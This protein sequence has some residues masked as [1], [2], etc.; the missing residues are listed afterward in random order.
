MVNPEP[1]KRHQLIFAVIL[2]PLD[3]LLLLL[4]AAT[5]Y[6]L[7]FETSLLPEAQS[8]IPFGDYLKSAALVGLVWLVIFALN[9]LYTLE[10]PRRALSET[11][12]VLTGCSFGLMGIIILIFFQ[13]E[14]FASRFVILAAWM[15]AIVFVVAGRAI[16]RIVQRILL[17][18]GITAIRS[19]VIGGNDATTDTIVGEFSKHP[20][21]GWTLAK[22]I[23]AWNDAAAAELEVQLR[24]EPVDEIF[25]ADTDLSRETMLSIIRFAEDHHLTLRYAADTLATHAVLHTTTV[26]GIPVIEVARTSLEGWGRVYK[27]VFD[28]IASIVL[29]VIL[30]PIMLIAAL[31]V[32]FTS[33]GPVVYRNERVGQNGKHLDVYK[34][35]S[36][37][38]DVSIGSQFG[39][40][41]AAL[42]YEAKLI[43][44]RGLKAGPVYKMPANDPR[45]TP[46]GR[47]IRKYS[48]DE[49]PQLFNVLA[50]N[51]SLVG[52]RPH[53][54]REVAKYERHHRRALV[55][56]PGITGL[57]QVS[58]R[59]DLDFEEE[60]RL[61]AFYVENWTPLMDLAILAKTPGA[62]LR[63]KG[64]Y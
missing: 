35:R 51:M 29:I 53:Q 61:D 9:G 44:E 5:A 49:L 34:F 2:V 58:G 26:A 22:R 55:V 21:R 37:F 48:I 36:M 39:G 56:K 25:V 8:L 3:Y 30:S 59:R 64:A 32:W 17:R 33:K 15:L 7:R 27:R 42:A 12:R 24:R 46:V 60:A 31:A 45:I 28:I 54:P 13:R 62:A 23:P 11:M 40:Q 47:F 63:G 19:V 6:R 16:V 20:E 41:E 38:A 4:A 50:G 14:L 43:T 57:A 1:M 10:R 18:R 52:P